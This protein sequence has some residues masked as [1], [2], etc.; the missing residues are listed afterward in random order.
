MLKA[1]IK[2]FLP[3]ALLEEYASRRW[4]S[5]K[6]RNI[7]TVDKAIKTIEERWNFKPIEIPDAPVFIFSAGWRS[8]STLIQRLVNS[9]KEILIWGEP[10]NKCDFIQH[11]S[12]SL[13]SFTNSH[14]SS[15]Y[16]IDSRN[17]AGSEDQL[18]RRWTANLYPDLKAF[19]D[20]HR[21]FYTTL[22]AKPSIERGFTRW[23]IKEV[24]LTIDHAHYLK[25]L[26][27][28]AKFLF[29]YRNPYK[30]YQSCHTWRDLYIRWPDVPVPTPEEFGSNW[31][32]M[33]EGYQAGVESIGGL[34]IKY[35]EFLTG[36]PPIEKLSEYLE[37]TLDASTMDQRIGSQS[38]KKVPLSEQQIKRLKKVVSPL[39]QQLGYTGL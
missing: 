8:G 5:E 15:S 1:T 26:F 4:Y 12:D 9:D 16:F 39:A 6:K 25:W 10:Y 17:F 14:P 23:G 19:V 27:P 37:L 30:A 34:L 29:L 3:D 36:K 24:R 33:I 38:Q 11:H 7:P 13:R 18:H 2:R 28:N 32:H 35:E 31:K 20:A 21:N 22:Y